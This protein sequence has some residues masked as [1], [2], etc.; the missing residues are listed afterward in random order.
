MW[1]NPQKT[2]DLVTLI[3]D[4]LSGKLRF[5]WR[6]IKDWMHPSKP[7][8][9]MAKMKKNRLKRKLVLISTFMVWQAG[10][11]IITMYILLNISRNKGK[12]GTKFGHLIEHNIRNIFPFLKYF[13][14]L[15]HKMWKETSLITFLKKFQ[16]EHI[17]RSTA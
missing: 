6:V 17:S 9:F 10:K 14:F 11:Q 2:V 1:P 15:M 13:S 5:S 3:E 7:S 16:I 12:H 8:W 4:I